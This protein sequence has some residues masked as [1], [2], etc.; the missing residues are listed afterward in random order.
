[1]P[2]RKRA[3]PPA[4]ADNGTARGLPPIPVGE[5]IMVGRCPNCR[6]AVETMVDLNLRYQVEAGGK[7]TV[8][9][10]MHTKPVEHR[11]GQISA[12]DGDDGDTDDVGTRPM[13]FAER[14]AGEK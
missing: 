3:T 2:P 4:Q 6:E 9:A 14:A 5:R 1:M 7:S 8:K 13:D 12:L 10:T 11:C